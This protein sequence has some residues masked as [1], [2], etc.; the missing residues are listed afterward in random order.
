MKILLA[1]GIY[2]PDAGGPATYTRAFAREL[3]RCGHKV[4]VICYADTDWNGRIGNDEK[5][6]GITVHRIHRSLSTW[7]RYLSY[8]LQAYRMAREV[9]V[10]YLQGP[11]SEGFPGMCAAKLARKRVYMKV[12][13]DYAW[14]VYMQA[15]DQGERELLDNFLSHAQH[16]GKIGWIERVERWTAKNA[17]RI[18]VPS[19]Y[20]KGVVHLWGVPREKISVIYNAVSSFPVGIDR[21]EFR[22]EYDLLDKRILFTAVRAVPWK[23]IDFL[24]RL[25]PRLDED[26]CLVVAGEGPLYYDWQS[27]AKELGVESQVRFV[28]KLNRREMGEWYRASDLFLLPSGYEGFPHVIPEAV[29]FGLP[30]LVSDKGGNPETQ[31]LLGSLVTVLPYLD[32][33]SWMKLIGSTRVRQDPK[34]LPKNLLFNEMVERTMGALELKPKG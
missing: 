10:V 2:P 21:N 18:I 25:M 3:K 11:V 32:A 28:G 9:D 12:V 34:N 8:F 30:C 16:K 23:N 4:E 27:L 31:E 1:T 14:E 26:F 5:D 13:G 15:F 6:D 33:E 19:K 22:R 24:I 17:E 20:L 29:S 7:G